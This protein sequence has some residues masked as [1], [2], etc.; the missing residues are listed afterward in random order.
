[1]SENRLNEY[2]EPKLEAPPVELLKALIKA[3]LEFNPIPKS[4]V[5]PH[6]K[7]S[8]ADMA[9]IKKACWIP[10]L[11]NGLV[12]TSKT[13][14]ANTHLITKLYHVESGEYLDTSWLFKDTRTDPQSRGSELTYA[15]RYNVKQILCLGGGDDDAEVATNGKSG[16]PKAKPKQK[17]S[18]EGGQNTDPLRSRQ[19][20]YQKW[21]KGFFENKDARHRWQK[22]N[23]GK[24]S[25]ADWTNADYD[26]AKAIL[27]RQ[28]AEKARSD[29]APK[30]ASNGNGFTFDN[31]TLGIA[32]AIAVDLEDFRDFAR[33][34]YGNE[35]KALIGLKPAVGDSAAMEG[36]LVR[37]NKWMTPSEWPTDNQPDIEGSSDEEIDQQ[38]EESD[39]QSFPEGGGF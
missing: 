28:V 31:V 36:V 13:N 15:E 20:A 3:Q 24:E 32:N 37:Y 38:A 19:V 12:I 17:A 26:N 4:N 21:A 39:Q 8:Y 35:G 22:E 23:V 11:N 33:N 9:D 25:T 16:K 29:I 10:L 14:D 30:P 5:N 6:F 7:F 1:M 2:E 27:S 18:I 34:E